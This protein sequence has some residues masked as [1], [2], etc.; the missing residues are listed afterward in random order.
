MIVI[1][2]FVYIHPYGIYDPQT[3]TIQQES[4]GILQK[5][6]RNAKSQVIQIA[7][8]RKED[9]AYRC[10]FL[11]MEIERVWRDFGGADL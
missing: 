4:D 8:L 2:L 1:W 3:R 5:Q 6:S 11:W 10:S 9:Q 7:S